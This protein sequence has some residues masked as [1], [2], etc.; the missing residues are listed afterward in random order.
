LPV[1]YYFRFQTGPGGDF[2]SLAARIKPPAAKVNAGKRNV[3]VSGPGF[4]VAAPPGVTL[5]FEGALRAQGEASSPRRGGAQGPY[6]LQLRQARGRVGNGPV[7]NPP[8]Y[9]GHSP[10]RTCRSPG[11]GRCGWAI[12]CR[13]TNGVG[14]RRGRA[15]QRGQEALRHRRDQ[16]GE[17]ARPISRCGRH[18]FARRVG[19]DVAP[20][21]GTDLADGAY[22]R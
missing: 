1:Y 18:N 22:R 8:V 9:G 12:S 6:E 17:I 7:V 11:P 2:A 3:D 19:V 21:F 16:L 20:A 13:S 14:G 5:D 15:V 4:G 10:A